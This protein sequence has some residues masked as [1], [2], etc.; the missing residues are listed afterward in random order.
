MHEERARTSNHTPKT[1]LALS[2]AAPRTYLEVISNLLD[3]G[4]TVMY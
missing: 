4:G 2:Q 3:L 1:S